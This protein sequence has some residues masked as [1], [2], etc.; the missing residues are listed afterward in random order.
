MTRSPWAPGLTTVTFAEIAFAPDGIP[1]AGGS[2]NVRCPLPPIAGPPS[3]PTAF[4]VS[5]TRQ[6]VSGKSRVPETA[7]IV[8]VG[9]GVGVNVDPGGGV[10]VDVGV[11]VGVVGVRVGVGVGFNVGV[12][13]GVGVEPPTTARQPADAPASSV[14]PTYREIVDGW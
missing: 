13:V 7:G 4:R 14:D 5:R 2:V 1:H 9:V 3:G 11:A 6:G 12:K 10:G 8:A